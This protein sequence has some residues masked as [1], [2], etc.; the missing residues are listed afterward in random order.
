MVADRGWQRQHGYAHPIGLGSIASSLTN[1]RRLYRQPTRA[2]DGFSRFRS[3]LSKK[4]RDSGNF[5]SAGRTTEN[6]H[7]VRRRKKFNA[8]SERRALKPSADI[9]YRRRSTLGPLV[10]RL[11]P[12]REPATFQKDPAL[13]KS[14]QT[15]PITA[16]QNAFARRMRD[17]LCS[18]TRHT[19]RCRAALTDG[20]TT[21]VTLCMHETYGLGF[22]R[23]SRCRTLL[24]AYQSI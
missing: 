19:G 21:N 3:P 9:L 12:N 18:V 1:S 20:P 24:W 16:S 7:A 15:K 13:G 11:D 10:K 4:Y 23:Y 17:L 14:L 2:I 22:L 8:R 6:G 5:F